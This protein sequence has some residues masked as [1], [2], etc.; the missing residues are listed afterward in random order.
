LSITPEAQ[1][2]WEEWYKT[3]PPSEH[4]KRLDAI[5]FRLLPLIALTTNKK[6]I[7]VE[8]IN[9]VIA[10]LKYELAVRTETDPIDADNRIA[11]LEQ[12]IRRQLQIHSKLSERDLRR[13]THADRAGLWAFQSAL[14]NLQ[15]AQEIKCGQ[16][17][18]CLI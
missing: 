10:I 3:L 14:T 17:G 2:L 18:Y 16:S 6:V 7:D 15:K 9:V 4:A 12:K 8:T 1:V 13:Y 11:E 5:G